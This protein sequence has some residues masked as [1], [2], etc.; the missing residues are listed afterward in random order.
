MLSHRWVTDR[1]S[2]LL[3]TRN[4][5]MNIKTMLAAAALTLGIAQTV[6]AQ[7]T[8]TTET[9]TYLA[10]LLEGLT[11]LDDKLQPVPAAATPAT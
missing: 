9:R 6:Q 2:P 5:M 3:K 10:H 8:E 11:M 1:A 7:Q 4:I